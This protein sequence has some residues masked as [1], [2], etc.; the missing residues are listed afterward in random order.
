M[1]NEKALSAK[2]T[3]EEIIVKRLNLKAGIDEF[4]SHKS[5]IKPSGIVTLKIENIFSFKK[6]VITESKLWTGKLPFCK[7]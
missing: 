6:A 3:T 2:I 7:R 1:M 4:V 5:E